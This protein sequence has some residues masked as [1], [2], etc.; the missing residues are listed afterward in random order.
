ML[1]SWVRAPA[2]SLKA[3]FRRGFF[4]KPHQTT[5]FVRVLAYFS[6]EIKSNQQGIYEFIDKKE[7]KILDIS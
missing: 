3:S 7:V 2:G 1:G 6:K 4:I 5:P